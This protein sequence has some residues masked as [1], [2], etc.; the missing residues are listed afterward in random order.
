MRNVFGKSF[1]KIITPFM[2]HKTTKFY[3]Q[4]WQNMKHSEIIQMKYYKCF[5]QRFISKVKK[6][7]MKKLTLG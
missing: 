7:L 4:K 1:A 2:G 6:K 5:L 3:H